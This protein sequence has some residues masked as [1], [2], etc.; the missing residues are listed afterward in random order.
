[1]ADWFQR[2]I[3]PLSKNI[4][5]DKPSHRRSSYNDPREMLPGAYAGE[6]NSRGQP[7][8]NDGNNL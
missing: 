7:I 5:L 4:I 8:G 1:M 6:R 2:L 3:M